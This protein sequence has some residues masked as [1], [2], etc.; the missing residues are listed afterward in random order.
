MIEAALDTSL[1]GAL[2]LR[3]HGH[4]TPIFHLPGCGRDSDRTLI[5]WLI[6]A[7]QA[8]GETLPAVNRWSVGTGPGS[9]AGL[10]CGLALAKAISLA[11]G[12]AVRG[13]PTAYALAAGARHRPG[14]SIGVL[15]DGRCGQVILSRYQ[16][17]ADGVLQP[18]GTPAPFAPDALSAAGVLCDV[19]ITLQAEQL[20]PLPESVRAALQTVDTL[21]PTPL[22]DAPLWPWP[23]DSAARELS[24]EPVYVRQAVFVKPSPPRA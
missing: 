24:C 6:E 15:H 12:A 9:F 13:V 16:A 21:D 4:L 23:T 20:P 17:A 2:V 19:W 3:R 7:L 18:A 22:L 5:P 11:S 14:Q 10:R 8:C 1:G